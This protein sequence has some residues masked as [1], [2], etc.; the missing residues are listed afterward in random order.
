MNRQNNLSNLDG[1][2][3]GGSGPFQFIEDVYS[4]PGPQGWVFLPDSIYPIDV[5]VAVVGGDASYSIEATDSP[6]YLVTGDATLSQRSTAQGGLGQASAY[7]LYDILESDFHFSITGPTAIRL[8]L[9]SGKV[10]ISIRS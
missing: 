6:P 7:I 9:A 3:G 2:I 1:N 4:A 8:N 5:T 10:Q